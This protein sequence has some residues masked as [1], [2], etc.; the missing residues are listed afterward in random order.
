[1]IEDFA[2]IPVSMFFNNTVPQVKQQVNFC[3][4]LH[5]GKT[6]YDDN[7]IDKY[8]LAIISY[9]SRIFS[10]M[11][12]LLIKIIECDPMSTNVTNHHQV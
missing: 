1:M 11:N 12:K 10:Y 4:I 5:F 8:D 2:H 6:F 9:H 3:G 7:N